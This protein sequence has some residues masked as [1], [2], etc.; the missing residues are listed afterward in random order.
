MD[1]PKKRSK[2]ASAKA[3]NEPSDQVME[4]ATQRFVKAQSSLAQSQ[5]ELQ[6]N[7]QKRLAESSQAYAE[8][9]RSLGEDVLKGSQESYRQFAAVV[10]DVAGKDDAQ[11]RIEDAY[12]TYAEQMQSAAKD[13]QNRSTEAYRTYANAI[14]EGQANSQKQYGEAYRAYLKS[15]QD[16]WA[17]ID[18]DAIAEL[19]TK[20]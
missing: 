1:N 12:R 17:K 16:A 9:I 3:D 18:I 10:Q 14:A 8:A 11:K 5:Q 19:V 20:G 7:G 4:E 2:T 13:A 6:V 15:L